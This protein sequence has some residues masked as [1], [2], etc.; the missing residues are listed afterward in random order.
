MVLLHVLVLAPTAFGESG[1][2]PL[3]RA[4]VRQAVEDL[5]VLIEVTEVSRVFSSRLQR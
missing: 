3:N 4:L 5:S 2:G 1:N